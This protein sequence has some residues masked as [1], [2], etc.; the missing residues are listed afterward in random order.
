MPSQRSAAPRGSAAL[1]HVRMGE[2]PPLVLLHGVGG[3][4]WVWKPVLARLAESRDVIAVDLPGHGA[5]PEIAA[6]V[7]P[8]PAVLA[9]T[10]AAFLAAAGIERPHVAGNSLGAWVALELA[11]QDAV[12][13]VTA[14]APAGLWRAPLAPKGAF[15]ARNAARLA[16]P[17]LPALLRTR[18]GRT[19]ALGGSIAHPE[20]VD[21]EGAVD[22]VQGYI[23]APGFV[24]INTEMRAGRFTG[25]EDVHVPVTVAWCEFDRLVARR[26]PL[27]FPARVVLLRGCGHIPMSDAPE[28]VAQVLLE[29]S[30]E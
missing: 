7:R 15:T 29:G 30:A 26:D 18:R 19:M 24:A 20:R 23:D 10:V 16:R 3:G 17:L 27:P 5:S 11:R 2:G 14:I 4:S 1:H 8:T 22:M 13:S 28:A 21:P 6:D 9:G 25:G 12:R